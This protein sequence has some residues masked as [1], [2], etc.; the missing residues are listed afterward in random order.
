M[1]T[2]QSSTEPAQPRAGA[3][4]DAAGSEP[5]M[6]VAEGLSKSFGPVHA[7]RDVSFTVARGE[8]VGFL[9][10]NGAG[11]STTMKMLTGSLLPDGGRASIAGVPLDG[12]SLGARAAVGYLPEHTPLYREMRVRPY[13][14]FVGEVHGMGGRARREALERVIA[15]CDLD[16]Y[17]GRR[18]HTLSKGYRQRV[19]LAQALF[20]D[21]D[22]LVLDEPTSGLDPAEIVRIRDL[23]VELARSKTIL[24]STHVLPEV[25]EVCRRVLIIAGGQLVADGPLHELAGDAADAIVVVVDSGG[26]PPED[27]ARSLG[28]CD[29]AAAARGTF[30]GA[31]ARVHVTLSPGADRYTLAE[32]LARA[33]H[34]AGWSLQE[35]RH[36]VPTLERVFLERT[37]QL[38]AAE[39]RDAS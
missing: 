18:I 3:T 21:P 17:V 4:A 20:T 39:E 25:E 6:I 5:P 2:D 16:G 8:L 29:G 31:R 27:V 24:L 37:R 11:K 9:G 35:L 23:V 32:G 19:G 38:A 13:L 14:E 26:A 28:A 36:E 33:V 1:T 15:S 30:D 34:G 12:R 10:P 7:V 22:V